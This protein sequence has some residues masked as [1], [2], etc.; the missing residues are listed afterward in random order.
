MKEP[1]TQAGLRAA[2]AVLI[3]SDNFAGTHRKMLALAEIDPVA[4]EAEALPSVERLARALD[5]TLPRMAFH[6][7]GQFYNDDPDF[8]VEAYYLRVAAAILAGLR[9]KP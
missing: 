5:D 8:D 9:E 3:L 6:K 4:I 2:H 1:R 7:Y